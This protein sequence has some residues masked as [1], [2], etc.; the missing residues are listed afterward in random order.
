ML[1][2]GQLVPR[3]GTLIFYNCF[4][5]KWSWV[6]DNRLAP[7]T[8]YKRECSNKLVLLN[9]DCSFFHFEEHVTYYA[10][11]CTASLWNLTWWSCDDATPD[12]LLLTCYLRG[13]M[14]NGICHKATHNKI[15]MALCIYTLTVTWYDLQ[16]NI[17]PL[18]L[19][20]DIVLA[21]S[22]LPGRGPTDV[23]DAPAPVL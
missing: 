21:A 3:C 11:S 13:C 19:K 9:M 12:V 6:F 10:I 20:I 14:T 5:T 2:N 1:T 18:F 23:D 7:P 17:V 8:R 4:L 15:R 22:Q 16:R